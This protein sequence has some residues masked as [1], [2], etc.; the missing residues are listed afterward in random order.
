MNYKVREVC[1]KAPIDLLCIDET[2]IDASFPDAQFNNEGYQYP[3]PPFRR[4]RHKNGGEK[5]I[6]IREVLIARQHL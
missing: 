2:K 3:H 1:R 5:M 4:D 6:F